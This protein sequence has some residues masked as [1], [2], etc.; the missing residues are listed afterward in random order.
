MTANVMGNAVA[1]L[2]MTN[3]DFWGS[4]LQKVQGNR[5]RKSTFDRRILH[6]EGG[7]K[8]RVQL[9][10]RLMPAPEI[11][12]WFRHVGFVSVLMGLPAHFI[13]SRNELLINDMRRHA[14]GNPVLAWLLTTIRQVGEIDL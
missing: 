9:N 5:G 12:G 1:E 7:I 6:R 2:V 10:N 3:N 4:T 13:P 11:S 14:E 8:T